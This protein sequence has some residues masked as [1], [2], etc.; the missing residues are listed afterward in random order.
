MVEILSGLALVLLTLVAYSAGATIAGQGRNV[1]PGL[2]D[3]AG[4]ATLWGASLI[5]RGWMDKWLAIGVWVLVGL[6]AGVAGT[7]LRRSRYPKKTGSVP[8][9][10]GG[11]GRLWEG[12]KAFGLRMGSYQ[13]RVLLAWFYF[14]V[15]LPF[16][17]AVRIF[18]D[19]LQVKTHQA[20]SAW[21]V[22][23]NP[24]TDLESSRSQF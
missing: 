4:V 24:V 14:L 6:V 15:V 16:G 19:P 21:A 7:T 9:H 3:V 18:R 11:L 17:L 1:T 13:S 12:W 23:E 22:R 2:I 10:I 8:A 20:E 5:T